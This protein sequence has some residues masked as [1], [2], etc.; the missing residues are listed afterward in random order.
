MTP[1]RLLVVF[2]TRPEAIKMAPV[3]LELQRRP[4]VEC[5]VCV[6]G[7]HRQL[8]DDALRSFGIEP[9]H[10]LEIMRPGQTLASV[11]AGVLD[12]LTPVLETIAPDRVLVHGDTTTTFSAALACFYSGVPVGHV[13]AGL[14]TRN[15]KSPWPE[16]FNRQTVDVLADLLWAPTDCAAE[17][18]RRDG[19][20]ANNIRVTGNTVIDAL[21]IV[22]DR[23]AGDDRL[24]AGLW[25][26]L[27]NLDAS[28]KLILVTGHRRENFGD[29]LVNTCNALNRLAE[30]RD[31]EIIWPVHPNPNVLKAVEAELTPSA[32]V[33]LVPPQDYFSFVALMMRATLIITD[34]G[35]IQEEA[36]AL[37]KPVLVTRQ[38]TERPEA[39]SA[40]TAKLVG[41][42]ARGLFDAASGL[43]DDEAA[44]ARMSQARNPFGDGFASKR[45]VDHIL[46]RHG[47][48]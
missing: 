42:A 27:P 24:Q 19:A 40:G 31:V 23:I 2:G 30:R 13:E 36:P 1:L 48:V 8:L 16:E 9:H 26:R 4:D 17:A 18:L 43:L 22:R 41:T 45:I 15:L 38:E 28:A 11:T 33:H 6:T 10:D 39:I 3:V 47:L 44:Y 37:G 20:C 7:Q 34:S 12:K 32:N 14:R 46:E 29:G 21:R 35:G 5:I 25:S